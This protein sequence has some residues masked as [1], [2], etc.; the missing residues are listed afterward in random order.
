MNKTKYFFGTEF[1]ERSQPKKFLG[2]QHGQTKPTIDLI[3]IGIV[4]EDGI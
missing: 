1:I 4:D 3:S 2:F